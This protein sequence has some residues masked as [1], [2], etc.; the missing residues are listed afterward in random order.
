MPRPTC[1]QTRKVVIC[2]LRVV[3]SG[4]SLS[5]QHGTSS[6]CRWSNRPQYGRLLRIR[7]KSSRG[8]PTSG[9]PP[10]WG[11]DEVLTA[12]YV[13]N[14]SCYETDKF[15][16]DLDWTF[17]TTKPMGKGHEIWYLEF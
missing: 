10:A 17:G 12:P 6:G 2:R 7:W 16:S 3:Y 8:Q 15:V 14:W 4:M 13:T 1:V 5:S 11:L 9:G